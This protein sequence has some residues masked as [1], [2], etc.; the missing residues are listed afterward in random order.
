MNVVK[1][2]FQWC[3]LLACTLVL[4]PIGLIVVALGIPFA[5]PD[6]SVSDGRFIANL[7]KIFWLFGNDHDGLF[8]DKR[9]KWAT[10]TPF[11]LPATHWFSMWWWAA[12]RNPV[13]NMRMV[14][15][16]QAPITGSMITYTGDYHVRDKPG[17]GG[18]QFVVTENKGR[19][20]YG[21]YWVKQYSA[22]RAFVVRFGYKVEPDDRIQAALATPTEPAGYTMKINPFKAIA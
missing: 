9:G 6:R 3:F 22:K 11:G 20:W 4:D 7:P 12:I 13:N 2:I 16:W 17:E 21:L 19:H 18:F 8:G 1:A 10:M 14:K 5:R 15:L